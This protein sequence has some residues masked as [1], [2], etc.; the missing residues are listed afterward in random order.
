MAGHLL[1]QCKMF[2]I[3]YFSI[4]PYLFL[5]RYC[6]IYQITP[7]TNFSCRVFFLV[8]WMLPKRPNKKRKKKSQWI[9]KKR[10]FDFDFSFALTEWQWQLQWEGTEEVGRIFLFWAERR[11]IKYVL[12]DKPR[13]FVGIFGF[14]VLQLVAI[15]RFWWQR[16]LKN[17][18]VVWSIS[19]V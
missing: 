9:K 10:K 17:F 19:L 11:G 5:T 2:L 8:R 18:N 1:R 13:F 15:E 3:F 4:S 6:F 14:Y 12:N 16:F 7:N